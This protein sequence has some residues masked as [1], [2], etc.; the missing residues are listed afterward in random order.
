MIECGRDPM[1]AACP[2]M[3][4]VGHERDMNIEELFSI[5]RT[6]TVLGCLG[7]WARGGLKW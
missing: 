2:L 4:D 3:V 6:R 5:A 7:P 1:G